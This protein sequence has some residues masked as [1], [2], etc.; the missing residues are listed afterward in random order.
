MS[1][2]VSKNIFIFSRYS[3]SISVHINLIGKFNKRSSL[4]LIFNFD[5][6]KY[7]GR[8]EQRQKKVY[9]LKSGPRHVS[10]ILGMA[11]D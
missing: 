9:Y 2:H 10:R 8:R 1:E 11:F 6:Q 4:K 7:S 3:Q 5:V